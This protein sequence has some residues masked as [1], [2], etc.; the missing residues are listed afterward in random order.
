[1]PSNWN[2][3][4]E[5]SNL[6]FNISDHES[7]FT[8]SESQEG[9]VEGL[10]KEGG[11]VIALDFAF[12]VG[13]N[14]F[15]IAAEFPQDLA[16][17]PAGRRE[18]VGVR[19][20]GDGVKS[21]FAFGNGLEDGDPLGAQRQSIRGVFYVAPGENSSGFGAYGR[22]HAEI[23]LRRVRVLARGSRRGDQCGVLSIH[24]GVVIVHAK[25]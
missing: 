21:A 1:L 6:K 14:H 19:D 11:H 7:R 18:R 20:D 16:A 10:G 15:R 3:A 9:M 12:E 23:G 8:N 17:R 22:A 24:P 25:S 5:N 2:R 13:E 4:F